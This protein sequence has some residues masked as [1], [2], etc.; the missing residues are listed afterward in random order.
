MRRR[1]KALLCERRIVETAEKSF[2]GILMRIGKPVAFAASRNQSGRIRR[3]R[4]S[5]S[6]PGLMMTCRTGV[7]AMTRRR[8]STSIRNARQATTARK[9]AAFEFQAPIKKPL[10]SAKGY[11]F[12]ATGAPYQA[13]DCEPNTP[14]NEVLSHEFC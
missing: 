13:P 4:N 3:R 5:R 10:A 11:A 8:R 7:D 12:R 6:L 14:T 2:C 9:R 1:L